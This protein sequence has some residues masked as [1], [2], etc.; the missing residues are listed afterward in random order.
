MSFGRRVDQETGGDHEGGEAGTVGGEC[1]WARGLKEG[2][3]RETIVSRD[4]QHSQPRICQR[5]PNQVQK[6][7][8]CL[9]TGLQRCGLDLGSI[10]ET[11]KH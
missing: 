7:T 8:P 4:D 2:Q 1:V 3:I 11:N 5:K 10:V 6:K 9:H